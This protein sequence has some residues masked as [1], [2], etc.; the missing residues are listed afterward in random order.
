[1]RKTIAP[2]PIPAAGCPTMA[3]DQTE[4]PVHG[5]TP[6]YDCKSEGLG[7]FVGREPTTDVA[8]EILAKSG[9]KVFRWLVPGQVVTME[10]RADRVN[11]YIGTNNR[12]ERVTCG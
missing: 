4:P 1:M 11:A 10:F 2:A 3:A 12:I 8:S 9:A 7:A 5:E 6:G